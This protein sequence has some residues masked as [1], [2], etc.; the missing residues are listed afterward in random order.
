M[1][2]P[3]FGR[4]AFGSEDGEVGEGFSG[5]KLTRTEDIKRGKAEISL[6][7]AEFYAVVGGKAG[8]VFS[9]V[10]SSDEAPSLSLGHDSH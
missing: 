2:L 6:P 9:V 4:L 7:A 5:K 3:D 1:I 8:D 10:G